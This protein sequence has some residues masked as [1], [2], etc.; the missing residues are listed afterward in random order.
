MTVEVHQAAEVEELP[1]DEV[2][3]EELTAQD[4]QQQDAAATEGAAEDAGELVVTLGDEPSPEEDERTAPTW[5]KDLRKQNRELVRKTRDL[6]SRLQQAQPAP[7]AVVVG[8]RPTL[9]ACE[10]DEDRFSAELDAWHARKAA[11]D[12][13]QRNAERQ[14]QAQA[15]AWNK[16]LGDYRKQAAALRVPGFDQ[17]EESVKDTLTIVQQGLLIRACKQPALMV[18]ALGNNERKAKELAG[19]ADPIEFVAELARL[20]TQLKTQARKPLTQPERMAPRSSVSGAAAVDD[21]LAKLQAHAAKTG[22]R[23]PVVRYLREKQRA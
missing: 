8:A 17:A 2:Q 6:E 12:E 7:S 13:Q 5:V 19:I 18:A 9:A 11:A 20:E 22:D 10:Y 21:Q 3:Q 23:T 14:H 4:D 16:R 1:A 15:E